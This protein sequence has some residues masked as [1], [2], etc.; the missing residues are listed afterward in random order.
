VVRVKQFLA[1]R[2]ERVL[3]SFVVCVLIGPF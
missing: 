3:T 2:Q 1:F